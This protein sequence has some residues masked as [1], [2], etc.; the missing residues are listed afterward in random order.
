MMT[1]LRASI[2]IGSNSV[3]LLVADVSHGKFKE[4]SKRSEITSLGRELDK[5]KKFHDESMEAT[6]LALKSYVEECK[7][8]GIA[9]EDIIATATEAA[10]VAEN[11]PALFEKIE[12]DLGLKIQ[13]LTS[14]GEAYYSTKGILF[15]SKF[16]SDVI[17]IMDIGG[18]STELIKVNTKTFQILETISMPMGAVR[19]TQW[20][21]D[22]LFV[23]NLQKV[24]LDF[25]NDLDKFQTQKLFC[26]AGTV[27]S[28]GNMF[29]ERTEFVEDD[30]H[31]LVIK[32]EDIDQMFKKFSH[33]D[34]DVFLEKFPFLQKRAKSIR[35]GLHLVYHIVHRLLVK[36]LSISTYGLRFGTL[37]EGKIK[38]EHLYS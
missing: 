23:Q 32:A 18:A 29:L 30:V 25:R 13:I 21:D 11:A 27:T 5:N 12:K 33:T 7:T 38:R 3:L 16:P 22:E 19:A 10:R 20:L 8:H 24:F 17:V 4:I 28:L 37:L 15:N 6:E 9:P 36:E 1:D 26:V 35:G 34:V 31:G 2:D 14:E